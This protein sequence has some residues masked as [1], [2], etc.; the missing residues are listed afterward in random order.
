MAGTCVIRKSELQNGGSTADASSVDCK[1]ADMCRRNDT[2]MLRSASQR[3]A[4]FAEHG[5]APIMPTPSFCGA[6]WVRHGLE[7]KIWIP[8]THELSTFDYGNGKNR[9]VHTTCVH[10]RLAELTGSRRFEPR[11]GFEDRRSAASVKA[12]RP[13]SGEDLGC[14]EKSSWWYDW[15]FVDMSNVHHRVFL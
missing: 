5:Q 12:R 8:Y 14:P 10:L 15:L 7:R 13:R 2:A 3:Y 11:D 6:V 9:A 1:A 4:V